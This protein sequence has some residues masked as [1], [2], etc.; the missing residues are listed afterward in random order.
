M[1]RPSIWYG[2]FTIILHLK[3]E[4]LDLGVGQIHY[5]QEAVYEVTINCVDFW[6]EKDKRE[7]LQQL[8]NLSFFFASFLLKSICHNVTVRIFIKYRFDLKTWWFWLRTFDKLLLSIKAI[9][10][11]LDWCTNSLKIRSVWP[12]QIHLYPLY[13]GVYVPVLQSDKVTNSPWTCQMLPLLCDF[14]CA[15]WQRIPCGHLFTC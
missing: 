1:A 7:H 13:Q 8:S 9:W 12:F 3:N 2:I 15:C 4:W 5:L 6:H 11:C 10:N 14:F